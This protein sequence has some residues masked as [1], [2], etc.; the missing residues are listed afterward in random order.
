MLQL[1]RAMEASDRQAKVIEGN[2]HSSQPAKSV[3]NQVKKNART[4]VDGKNTVNITNSKYKP[5]YPMQPQ[6]N[7]L[8]MTN[9][10]C[11]RCG[12]TN[13]APWQKDKC[14]AA[15]QQCSS[16]K[17]I[18]HFASVCR[19][20]KKVYVTEKPTES[21][22][23]A[24]QLGEFQDNKG[25]N[26]LHWAFRVDS[27][28]SSQQ[29][30]MLNITLNG[31]PVNMQLDTAADV[32]LVSE[33]LAKSIPNVQ[34]TPSKVQ[35]L[36]YSGNNIKVV[37]AM[38]VDVGYDQKQYKNLPVIVVEGQER[39]LFGLNWLEHIPLDWSNIC[40]VKS[41]LLEE[42]L[43]QVLEQSKEVFQDGI[44][45]VKNA[46]ASLQLQPNAQPKFHPPRQIPLPLKPLVEQEI[47]RLVNNGSWEKVTYSDWG[48][49]IVPV[50]KS[51]GGIRLCGD[52]KVTVNPQL[53]VAQHPL[54]KPDNMFAALGGC[55]IFSKLD[56][57]QAF[58]Q[59]QMD[60]VS[61]EMCT[62][63]THLGLYRPKRLPYGVASSPALWQQTMDKLFIGKPGI[64][65]FVDDILVAGKDEV[66]HL[67]RL[68]VVLETLRS[69][70]LRI[71]KDKCQFAVPWVEYLGFRVDGHVFHLKLAPSNC[72][73]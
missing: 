23:E 70:G 52:Y 39:S 27:V 51:D 49:P 9:K 4:K 35:L 65:C 26:D 37:G 62:L 32:T 13:H 15:S 41:R 69:T 14:P 6:S 53:Q 64:F 43:S 8:T 7:K 17:K 50:V 63:S 48:T 10:K 29:R 45:T 19:T 21:N 55:K 33:N 54:P 60:E 16:C 2:N 56:L 71:R 42:D 67:E 11:Y 73:E 31:K 28:R 30:I 12:Y 40:S 72:L 5:S 1:A 47:Q 59:L 61:Q 68:K 44:G 36:D 46:C 66:Q 57:R 18:G 24:E 22:V 25:D 38:N 58:Q 3:V 20:K 34:I